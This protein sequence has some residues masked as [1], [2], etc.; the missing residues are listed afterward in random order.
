MKSQD[1]KT[2]NHCIFNIQYHL[3]LVTKYRRKVITKEILA[4]LEEIF[5]RLLEQWDCELIE[6]NGEADHVHL[7]IATNPKAQTSKLVNNL[8]TVT[9][10]LIRKE[11]AQQVNRFY[12]KPVFWSRT[13]CLL[14]V[15]GAP[16]S[17]LKQYIE[18]QG[19]IQ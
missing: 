7:L 3:V 13:Y 5:N 14:S 16:L 6:F 12:W 11:F 8:K 19:E 15:G 17:V 18:N 1:L 4:R 10:R 9:S 2:L